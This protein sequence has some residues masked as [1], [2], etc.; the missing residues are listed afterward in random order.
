MVMKE[1]Q[2]SDAK[3]TEPYVRQSNRLSSTSSNKETIHDA[4]PNT[5]N[6]TQPQV[7]IPADYFISHPVPKASPVPP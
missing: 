2:K 3:K 1:E 6:P 5:F 7:I 4:T